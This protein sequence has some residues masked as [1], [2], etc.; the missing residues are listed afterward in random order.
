MATTTAESP[1]YTAALGMPVTTEITSYA[2]SLDYADLVADANSTIVSN[3]GT[4]TLVDCAGD[5]NGDSWESD[6]GCVA[7]DNLGNDCD[8]CA[9]VPDG[10]AQDLGCGCNEPAAAQ[11]YD[12]DDACLN[13][14]DA[15]GVC[16]ELEVAGC[17]DSSACNHD[18]SA[19]DSDGS[20]IYATDYYLDADGD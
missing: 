20:C 7:V 12:C 17:T 10:D 11:Y 4:V 9:G 15:D 16:N 2:T 14:T 6:C 3:D 5:A 1:L 8:D 13:D 19:T 18:S